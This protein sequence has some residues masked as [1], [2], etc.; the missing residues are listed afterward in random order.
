MKSGTAGQFPSLVLKI[1]SGFAFEPRVYCLMKR[2]SFYTLSWWWIFGP[3]AFGPVPNTV[4]KGL[5]N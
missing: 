2:K 5:E 1:T 3:K 4:G